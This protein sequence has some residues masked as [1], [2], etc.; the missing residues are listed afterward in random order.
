MCDPRKIELTECFPI[1]HVKYPA[2]G[3]HYNVDS[4]TKHV[5]ILAHIGAADTGV[6]LC[7]HVVAQCND[8]LLNLK[9]QF[10]NYGKQE[11]NC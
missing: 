11:S 10:N 5:D 4:L 8:D 2:G 7:L 3:T 9:R 6:A 1:D